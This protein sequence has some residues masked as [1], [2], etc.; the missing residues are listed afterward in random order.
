NGI[1]W[2][3]THGH[4]IAS[5]WELTTVDPGREIATAL[6]VDRAI[7]ATVYFSANVAR[8]GIVHHDNGVRMLLGEPLLGTSERLQAITVA[9]RGAGFDAHVSERLR[10]EIW[11]KLLGNVNFNPISALTRAYV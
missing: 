9:M 7:G 2:W 3:Y 11:S 1:P 6:E 8:P 4:P 5:Q 10:P